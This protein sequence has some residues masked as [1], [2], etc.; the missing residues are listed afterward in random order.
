[1][2]KFIALIALTGLS[3]LLAPAVSAAPILISGGALNGTDVGEIDRFVK[4]AG[5]LEVDGVC[6]QNGNSSSWKIEKCWA[7]Y[8]LKTTLVYDDSKAEGVQTFE[9]DMN[10]V[11][12]FKLA[13]G[14]GYYIIKNSKWWALVENLDSLDWGV[15]RLGDFADGLKLDEGVRISHVTQFNPTRVPEPGALALLGLG[16]LGLVVVRRRMSTH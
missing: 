15:I 2:R 13:F 5:S 8:E 9:T 6:K 12:A 14:P 16:L 3:A 4:D 10:G 7:E 1:M 11:I